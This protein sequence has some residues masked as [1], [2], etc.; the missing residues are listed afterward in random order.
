[1]QMRLLENQLLNATIMCDLDR[2]KTINDIYGHDMGDLYIQ[3]AAVL[4]QKTSE[5]IEDEL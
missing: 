4:L 5:E 1:M 3:S 2:V